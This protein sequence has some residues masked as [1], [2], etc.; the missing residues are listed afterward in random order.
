M[1][2]VVAMSTVF[3]SLCDVTQTLAG[4]PKRVAAMTPRERQRERSRAKKR[5]LDSDDSG[6]GGMGERGWVGRDG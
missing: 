3:S 1:K 5:A 2:T 6:E 4:R